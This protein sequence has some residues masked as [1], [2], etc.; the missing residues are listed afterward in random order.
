MAM[1][2]VWKV[3]HVGVDEFASWTRLFR[4]Y[5]NFYEWPTS[6]DHQRKIWSWIH[7][8]QSVEALVAV[9][10]D[11]NGNEVD[12]PRGLAHLRE[13]VRPLRGVTCGYLDDLYV[14]PESRGAG[15]VDALFSEMNGLAL[16]RDWAVIR[17]TT[18]DSNMR[19]QGAYDKVARRTSW[20]TYDM[21]PVVEAIPGP[22]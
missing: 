10:T 4:G 6:D 13:W 9:E 20:I 7:D 1:A 21:T 22:V 8:V 11:G 3:R 18:A 17:W 14:D 2:P 15:A 19:A 16:Q 12:I 5:C